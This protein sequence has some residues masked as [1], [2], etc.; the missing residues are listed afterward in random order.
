[1]RSFRL[2]QCP[3]VL[4]GLSAALVYPDAAVAEVVNGYFEG[5]IDYVSQSVGFDNSVYV[6]A[7]FSGSYAYDSEGAVDGLPDDPTIGRYDFDPPWTL[8]V[9]VGNY[10][11]QTDDLRIQIFDFTVDEFRALNRAPFMGAGREWP[12][13][14][15]RLT[16]F[17]AAAFVSDALPD[18]VPQ[19]SDFGVANFW[20]EDEPHVTAL[21]GVLTLLVPEPGAFSLL[22]LGAL[23][24]LRRRR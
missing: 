24:A 8:R 2:R 12:H 19:L 23:C 1:M 7:P 6:G 16:D 10:S 14:S 15:M 13:M 3:V 5:L 21:S 11:F 18:S 17:T 4:L 20:L 9:V 22:A